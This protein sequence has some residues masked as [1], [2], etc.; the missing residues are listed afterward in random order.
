MVRFTSEYNCKIDGKGRLVLPA[1]LKAAL[2]ET[3]G[4]TLMLMQGFEPCLSLYPMM[5]YHKIYS[6]IVGLDELK[7]EDRNIQRNFFRRS[8]EVE[9]DTAGRVLI[10]KNLIEAVKIDKEVQVIGAGSKI[11]IWNPELFDKYYNIEGDD[12]RDLVETI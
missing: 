4:N 1:R 12:L 3:G 10:P 9:L 2:P 8:V 5:E 11:E 6:K 7:K